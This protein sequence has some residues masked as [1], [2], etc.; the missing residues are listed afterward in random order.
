MAKSVEQKVVDSFI[1][2]ANHR[3][4]NSSEFAR[5]MSEQD[6]QTQLAFYQSM[7]SFITYKGLVAD[8]WEHELD[9][10]TIL[11]VCRYLRN[12]LENYFPEVREQ[13]IQNMNMF[14]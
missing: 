2:H 13:R 1:N 10:D 12:C 6:H 3:S 7:I 4:F 5:L 14:L 9:K 11:D 8:Y